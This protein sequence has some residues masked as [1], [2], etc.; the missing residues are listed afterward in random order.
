MFFFLSLVARARSRVHAAWINRN[1][2][3]TTG[4]SGA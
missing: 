3:H 1:L 2:S 4:M